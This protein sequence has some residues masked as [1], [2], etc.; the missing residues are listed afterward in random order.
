MDH[1]EKIDLLK[2]EREQALSG[3]GAEKI[4][5]Q[6]K[7]GKLTAR[8]RLDI[9]LDPGS[10]EEQGMF[11]TQRSAAFGASEKKYYGDGVITGSGLVEGGIPVRSITI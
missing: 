10:F 11:I 2:A 5:K 6:H 1:K 8:E 9:L 7:A 3:G 4:A